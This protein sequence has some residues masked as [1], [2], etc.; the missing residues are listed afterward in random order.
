MDQMQFQ[1]FLDK[2]IQI[3]TSLDKL[4]ESSN[5]KED[6][7]KDSALKEKKGSR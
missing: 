3:G 1:Q 2:L 7:T 5:K 4:L 6:P